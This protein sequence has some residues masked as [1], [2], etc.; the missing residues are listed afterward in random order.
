MMLADYQKI[1]MNCIDAFLK[2]GKIAN[3]TT[4]VYN[5]IIIVVFFG[6]KNI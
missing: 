5:N 3:S 2:Y 6:G 4:T 1:Q